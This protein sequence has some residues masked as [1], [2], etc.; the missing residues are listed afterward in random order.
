MKFRTAFFE[1]LSIFFSSIGLLLISLPSFQLKLMKYFHLSEFWGDRTGSITGLLIS[2]F[3]M[4]L[5]LSISSFVFAFRGKTLVRESIIVLKKIPD[6]I[7]IFSRKFIEFNKHI[8]IDLIWLTFPLTIGIIVRLYF[9]SQP[10]R[11]DEAYTFLNFAN[12]GI[13]AI[14]DYPVPNNHVLNTIL[15]KLSTSLFGANQVT[16]RLSA[17][18]SG[19]ISIILVFYLSQIL[20]PGKYSGI[21]SAWAVAV[22]PYLILYSTNARGYSLLISITLILALA[23][24]FLSTHLSVQNTTIFAAISSLGLFTLPSMVLGLAGIIIWVIGMLYFYKYKTK[25]ILLN[26]LLPL[27]VMGFV[28]TFILYTPVIFMANGITPIT[29]NKFVESQSWPNFLTNFFPQIQKTLAETYRDIPSLIII[30]FTCLFILGVFGSFKNRNRFVIMLMPSLLFGAYS[31]VF[32]QHTLPYARSWIYLLPFLFIIME[33][34]FVFLIKYISPAFYSIFNAILPVLA[35]IF[36]YQL[37]SKNIIS[38]YPDTSAF[39]EAPIVVQYLKPIFKESDIIHI[40]RTADW[41][42][43]YYFWYYHLPQPALNNQSKTASTYIIL[44][45]SIASQDEISDKN[46]IKLLDIQN[47]ALYKVLRK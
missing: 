27:S 47:M 13:S 28:F 19:I 29:A 6:K 42:V 32:F 31:I 11:G 37:M 5:L 22:F 12:K 23:G 18:F 33:Y 17:F 15:I 25:T 21:I 10:M 1:P 8:G 45:K 4:L 34:G 41:S 46:V 9:L 2:Y 39:P 36:V 38:M 7:I 30:I 20:N 40:S 44:K 35:I 14:F 26:F 43:Y 3:V 16:I 24:I